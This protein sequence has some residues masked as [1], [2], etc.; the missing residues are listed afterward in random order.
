MKQSKRPY[1]SRILNLIMV[2]P[3]LFNMISNVGTLIEDDAKLAGKSL[4]SLIILYIFISVIFTST[5]LC[6]LAMLFVYLIML[7]LSW[8]A[9][10]SI[11]FILNLLLMTII[12][13]IML[14]VKDNL[15]FQ[16]T[17]ELIRSIPRIG[18]SI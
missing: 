6:L 10:L 17:R 5:W 11:I 14:K 9:A 2:I 15:S 16:S 12:A 18:K 4:V 13:L 3:T 7:K 1:L 8:L